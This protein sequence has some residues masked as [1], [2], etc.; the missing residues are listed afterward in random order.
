VWVCPPARG[1]GGFSR[2]T[3]HRFAAA[4]ARRTPRDR[5]RGLSG[6]ARVFPFMGQRPGSGL[7]VFWCLFTHLSPGGRADGAPL[8]ARSGVRP[9]PVE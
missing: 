9:F 6:L 5:A 2:A 3:A 1:C 8:F 7:L 4:R